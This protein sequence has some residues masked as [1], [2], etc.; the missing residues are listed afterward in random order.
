MRRVHGTLPNLGWLTRRGWRKA[1]SSRTAD[2]LER[3]AWTGT[4]AAGGLLL[5]QLESGHLVIWSSV[6]QAGALAALKVLVA[7]K[8]GKSDSGSLPD[9]TDPAG[10]LR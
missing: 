8:V 4:Q 3:V 1:V 10:D 6:L 2:F 9:T 5:S 7:Q